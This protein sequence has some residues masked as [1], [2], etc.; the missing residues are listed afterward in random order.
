M[1]VL[2]PGAGGHAGYW[3]LVQQ[4]LTAAGVDSGAVSLPGPDPTQGLREYV[5]RVVAAA[6]S[7]EDV[8]IVG[9]SLGGFAA[10]WAA[11]ELGPR[12]LVLLNAMVPRPGESAGQ[13]WDATGS[14]AARAEND[15]RIGRDPAAGVDA[16]VH[17]LHD[18]PPSAVAP[19]G[20]P[21]EESAAV[22]EVPWGPSAWPD[23][24]TRVLAG[25]DDRFFPLDFQRRIARER[26]GIDVETVPGG[27]LAALSHPAEVAAALLQT[28]P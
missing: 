3:R 16:D 5:D 10:A 15:Q 17:F 1:Y 22:F 18:V 21:R 28:S 19:L 11:A 7:S 6:A 9:Q 23:V 24:P 12:G 13:W 4:Q 25:V 27:H 8:V 20:A 26:L 2:V 14:G